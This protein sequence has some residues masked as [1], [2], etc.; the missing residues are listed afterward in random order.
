MNLALW[1]VVEELPVGAVGNVGVVGVDVGGCW[2]VEFGG[3]GG[4]AGVGGVGGFCS[5]AIASRT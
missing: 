1:S 2:L 4:V 5:A 3:V